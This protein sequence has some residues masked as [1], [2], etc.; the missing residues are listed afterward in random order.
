MD[1]FISANPSMSNSQFL[2]GSDYLSPVS[3]VFDSIYIMEK[4]H[5]VIRVV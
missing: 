4:Y 2:H 1:L 5:R 3:V